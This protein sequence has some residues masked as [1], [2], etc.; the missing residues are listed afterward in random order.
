MAIWLMLNAS[1][2]REVILV[3]IGVS[4]LLAFYLQPMAE[5]YGDIRFT[6]K[7]ILYYFIYL[8]VFVVELIKS[9]WHVAK[10]VIS[11]KIN[12]SPAVVKIKTDLKTAIG[13]LALCNSITLTP[14]TLVVDIQGDTLYVHC[15]DVERDNPEKDVIK[16]AAKFEKYLKVVYG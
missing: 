14:G 15:I 9:N 3:G 12:I 11:P 5:K 8:M 2:A 13:R 10:L 1:L 6:P 16:M 4:A 7:V